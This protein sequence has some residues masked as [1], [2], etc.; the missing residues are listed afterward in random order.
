MNDLKNRVSDY[1]AGKISLEEFEDRFVPAYWNVLTGK[2]EELS[3][4][5]YEIELRLAEYSKGYWTEDEL[6]DLLL[7]IIR[8]IGI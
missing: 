1:I 2:D 3:Q 7:F 6:K 8:D 4:M 5:V